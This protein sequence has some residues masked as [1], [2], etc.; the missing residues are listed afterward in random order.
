MAITSDT[1]GTINLWDINSFHLRSTL[2]H[3][4]AITKL[5]VQDE[6]LYS[7]S[8]DKTIK[9]WDLR[10]GLMVK[11]WKGHQDC[12]LD[13]C[14]WDNGVVSCSDDGNCLL[15]SFDV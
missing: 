15:F 9:V 2:K 6:R 8:A 10:S 5:L 4:D 1:S 7:S 13:F 14:L 11:V 3:D 12:I